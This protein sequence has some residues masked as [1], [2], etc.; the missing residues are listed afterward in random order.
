MSGVGEDRTETGRKVTVAEAAR[1][2]DTTA[3]A[4]RSRIKRGTLQSIKENKTVYVL[5]RPDQ[6]TTEQR[7]DADQ[8]TARSQS[9]ATALIAEMRDHIEDL[10]EQLEAERQAHSEARRL[11]LSALEKIPA[12]IEP[13]A[14]EAPEPRE[15]PE[16]ADDE[17]Q[18]RGP[19]PDVGGP[20]EGT[21][22]RSWW[23]EFFGF[24]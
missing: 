2:L 15:S 1:V 23:R 8:T 3:E 9:D 21:E 18:G 24:D 10:R 13:P 14:S 20:Q 5:L 16:M 6:T 11:L 17:R 22:R 4:I 12:A 19:V 7:P